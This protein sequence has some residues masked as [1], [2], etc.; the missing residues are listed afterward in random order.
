[1]ISWHIHSNN[2]SEVMPC[3]LLCDFVSSNSSFRL[4]GTDYNVGDCVYLLPGTVDFR[5]KHKSQ[6]T[7]KK[8]KKEIVSSAI[9]I[10]GII[11]TVWKCEEQLHVLVLCLFTLC[12]VSYHMFS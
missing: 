10:I 7:P 5:V 9:I 6:T 2:N 3:S 1:M 12:N 11:V 4:R 8:P